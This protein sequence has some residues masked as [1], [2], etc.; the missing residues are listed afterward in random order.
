MARQKH[1]RHA[2]RE[3]GFEEGAAGKLIAGVHVEAVGRGSIRET[4]GNL[5]G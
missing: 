4:I 5:K 1:R 3:R 2:R